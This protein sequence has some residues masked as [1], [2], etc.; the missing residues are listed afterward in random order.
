[1]MS[2][3]KMKEDISRM[4]IESDKHVVSYNPLTEITT[5]LNE[6]FIT[7]RS[8]ETFRCHVKGGDSAVFDENL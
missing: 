8:S 2:H 3:E 7:Q 4:K 1:M 6:V 5:S